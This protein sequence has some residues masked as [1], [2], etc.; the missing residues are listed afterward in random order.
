MKFTSRHLLRFHLSISWLFITVDSQINLKF[1][2]HTGFNFVSVF[3]CRTGEHIMSRCN[4][5]VKKS[6][7]HW[8]KQTLVTKT[9][10]NINYF[11]QFTLIMTYLLMVRLIWSPLKVNF[12][13]IFQYNIITWVSVHFEVGVWVSQTKQRSHL[14]FMRAWVKI[15]AE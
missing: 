12:I 1:H 5:T 3:F 15:K 2:W 9:N 6:S 10:N 8:Q 4:S 7:L 11:C 13:M 14:P